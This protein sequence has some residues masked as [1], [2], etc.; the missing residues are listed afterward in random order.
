ML[1]GLFQLPLSALEGFINS[2]FTLMDVPL[3]SPYYS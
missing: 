3:P 2:L 1:K